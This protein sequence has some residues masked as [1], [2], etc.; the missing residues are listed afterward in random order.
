MVFNTGCPVKRRVFALFCVGHTA[1]QKVC[2]FSC[3]KNKEEPV[4]SFF[5]FQR[6][7]PE[8]TYHKRRY[9]GYTRLKRNGTYI[10]YGEDRGG[11]YK[12]FLCHMFSC[13]F[14]AERQ[15]SKMA[16]GSCLNW[17]GAFHESTL[18]QMTGNPFATGP[19]AIGL[20]IQTCIDPNIRNNH[21]NH[22]LP[23]RDNRSQVISECFWTPKLGEFGFS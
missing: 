2:F 8:D 9:V 12:L 21:N 20:C 15:S 14:N 16:L 17:W 10:P 18:F 4:C 7:F 23:Y 19:K 3:E 11:S 22:V 1:A 13:R 6:S 5:T